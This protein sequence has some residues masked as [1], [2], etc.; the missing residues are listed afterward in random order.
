MI[1]K[2]QRHGWHVNITFHE[3]LN[4][5]PMSVWAGDLGGHGMYLPRPIHPPGMYGSGTAWNPCYS[6]KAIHLVAKSYCSH[7]AVEQECSTISRYKWPVMVAWRKRMIRKPVLCLQRRIHSSSSC[8]AHVRQLGAD[9]VIPRWLD[10]GDSRPLV[11]E[12]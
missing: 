7:P 5:K 1:L 6:G 11:F 10:Y 3:S 8:L 2:V 9:S 4:E 12:R